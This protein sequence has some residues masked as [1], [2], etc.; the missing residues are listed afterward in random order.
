MNAFVLLADGFEEC[1]ALIVVD[2]LRRAGVGT[3][4]ASVMG[5]LEVVSSRHIH[6]LA[7]VQAEEIAFDSAD[8]LVLPG[9]RLGT[10]NLAKSAIVREQ[11]RI[12]AAADGTGGEGNVDL[13]AH[14]TAR[15]GDADPAGKSL[16]GEKPFSEAAVSSEQLRDSG[17]TAAGQSIVPMGK[18]PLAHKRLAAIC[19]APSL[20][21]ELGLLEGKPATCHPD[22]EGQM[23]GAV[24]T[25]Q[26]VTVAGNIITGQGLGAT[27]DFAF[28]L[29][30][31]LVGEEK[32][33]QIK[34]AICW[35]G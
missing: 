25:G 15:G 11:C 8:L 22:F 32:V 7:D 5:R 16:S 20:L 19:A 2:I 30:R 34:K 27:F 29:V 12:F 3:L 31:Q 26:S 17:D 14:G 23:K 28:E 33:D 21:A 24:L 18:L 1:E 4:M 6:V 9:G 10:E 35:R 13:A